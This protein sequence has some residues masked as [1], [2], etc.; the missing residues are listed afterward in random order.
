MRLLLIAAVSVTAATLTPSASA[1]SSFEVSNVRPGP[2]QLMA[3]YRSRPEWSAAPVT[4]LLRIR[5][6]RRLSFG[7]LSIVP[8]P[9]WHWRTLRGPD[10]GT[11]IVQLSNR[12]LRVRLGI[13]PIKNMARR[14]FVLTLL[15][16]GKF[17]SVR[18][19][20]IERR[21][22]LARANPSRPRGHAVAQRPFCSRGGR[23]F[24]I[25]F[26]YGSEWVPQKVLAVVN[27]VLRTLRASPVRP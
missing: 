7:I 17:G 18:A 5:S 8:P 4:T 2:N 20:R 13:D 24:S 21:D 19:A 10:P 3:P 25:R 14:T 27:G 23:C 11:P 26:E 12:S 1:A 15:P 9:D 22:F 6:P 16:L